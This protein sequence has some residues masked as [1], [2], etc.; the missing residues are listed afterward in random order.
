[1]LFGD[2]ESQAWQSVRSW[3]PEETGLSREA[4]AA[5]T[6][7][8]SLTRFLERHFA[9]QLEVRLHDQFIDHMSAEEAR[10]LVCDSGASVLRRQVS[11]VYRGS[12]MFDAESVLPLSD[13]PADLMLELQEGRRPLGNLLLDRGLSLSRSDLSVVLLDVEGVNGGRWARRSVLRSMSG[14]R[15]LVVEVF[16]PVLWQRVDDP[17]RR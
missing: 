6:T 8:D 17:A 14:T 5:L 3:K 15:A 12:V 10:L 13:L 16:N 7:A 2:I 1:M 11:L 9:I 4:A